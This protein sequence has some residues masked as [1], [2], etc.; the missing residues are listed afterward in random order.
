MTTIAVPATKVTG[1]FRQLPR[2]ADPTDLVFSTWG[3]EEDLTNGSMAAS[4]GLTTERGF[5]DHLRELLA[6]IEAAPA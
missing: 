6:N 2:G 5:A 1:E 3:C 4:T